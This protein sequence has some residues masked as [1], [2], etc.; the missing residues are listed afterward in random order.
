MSNQ[1]IK[2][3]PQ[4]ISATFVKQYSNG[5]NIR[6]GFNR[7]INLSRSQ[8]LPCLIWPP[9]HL[10]CCSLSRRS[11]SPVIPLTRNPATRPAT[12][13]YGMSRN[14]INISRG[15]EIYESTV[16]PIFNR[17]HISLK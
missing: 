16:D 7:H 11:K 8:R 9:S 1:H 5:P 2:D 15:L 13:I 14:P 6:T 4:P 3:V 12:H 10:C 17:N